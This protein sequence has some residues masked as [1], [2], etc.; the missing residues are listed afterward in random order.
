MSR[1]TAL[2]HRIRDIQWRKRH[3]IG[4]GGYGVV[5]EI[6]VGLCVKVGLITEDEAEAQRHLARL[7]LAVPVLDYAS[8]MEL[9]AII[10]RECCERHGIRRDL[11][12]K[13][14]SQCTCREELDALLMPIADVDISAWSEEVLHVFRL[15]IDHIC[16]G[17]LGRIWDYRPANLACYRGH[18]VALDFGESSS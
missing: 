5:Y 4:M 9:A 10:H 6:A 17:E 13:D 18:L 11:F 14:S 7:G 12:S 8:D 16:E 3:L 2:L 15:Q 1:T